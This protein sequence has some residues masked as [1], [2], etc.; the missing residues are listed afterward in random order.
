MPRRP[1]SRGAAGQIRLVRFLPWP[2]RCTVAE[3]RLPN[4]IMQ[5]GM[6]FGRNPACLRLTLVDD[7]SPPAAACRG[8]PFMI[9]T[10]AKVVFCYHFSFYGCINMGPEVSHEPDVHRFFDRVSCGRDYAIG[11]P[12]RPARNRWSG[13][14]GGVEEIGTA[15]GNRMRAL[16]SSRATFAPIF[17]HIVIRILRDNLGC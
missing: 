1:V 16:K 13:R 15:S 8:L 7:P 3:R 9:V 6:P 2:V 11:G 10:I 5:P 12:S 17:E 14:D 4:G